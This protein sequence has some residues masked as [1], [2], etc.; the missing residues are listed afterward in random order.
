MLRKKKRVEAI[1]LGDM[2]QSGD[3]SPNTMYM[4]GKITLQAVGCL[5]EKTRDVDILFVGFW[6]LGKYGDPD[7]APMASTGY[8]IRRKTST[9]CPR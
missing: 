6:L 8:G 2:I 3:T 4:V 7:N 5:S 1:S 9:R